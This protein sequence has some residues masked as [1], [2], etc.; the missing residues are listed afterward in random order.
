LSV[1]SGSVDIDTGQGVV[2]AAPR[3]LLA[4]GARVLTHSDG[5]A[6]LVFG[7]GSAVQL[8]GDSVLH[9][10][11]GSPT[12][13][14]WPC[15]GSGVLLSRIAPT[16]GNPIFTFRTPELTATS[17][18][19]DFGL[20]AQRASVPTDAHGAALPSYPRVMPDTDNLLLEQAVYEDNGA[21]WEVRRW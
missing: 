15:L 13:G 21:L 2:P 11:Q 16:P 18:G 7:N 12:G 5:V 4:T 10:D 6:L 20:S 19:G 1:I 9:Y 3:L 14:I 8:G 17:H